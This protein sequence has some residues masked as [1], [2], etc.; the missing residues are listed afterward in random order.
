MRHTTSLTVIAAVVLMA[1]PIVQVSPLRRATVIFAHPAPHPAS[2]PTYDYDTTTAGIQ[3]PTSLVLANPTGRVFSAFKVSAMAIVPLAEVQAMLPPGFI[4]NALAPPN[5]PD[6][7]G[8]GLSFDFQSRCEH[9]GHGIGGPASGLYVLHTARNTAWNRNEVV[10]LAAELS[11]S[12]FVNCLNGVWGPGS[13]RLATVDVAAEE[14]HG[15]LQL[16]FKVK[17]ETIGLEVNVRAEGPSAIM[18]RGPHADPVPAPIRP[19]QNGLF[20]NPAHRYSI[21]SDAAVV[22]ATSSTLRL[23]IGNDESDDSDSR[24]RLHLPGGA[25]TII[26]LG[27]TFNLVRSFENFFQLE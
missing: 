15:K 13:S 22:P 27:P 23:K 18:A 6:V 7:A 9:L 2:P 12:S 25:L 5:P 24:G 21:M 20:P 16:T 19:F 17:D 14:K 11:D 8:I 10:V 1:L 3:P 4:A 26:G